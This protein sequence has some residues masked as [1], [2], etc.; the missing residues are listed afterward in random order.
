MSY[1]GQKNKYSVLN[2]F[3]DTQANEHCAQ[4]LGNSQSARLV[5]SP[6]FG[7]SSGVD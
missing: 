6:K 3:I 4:I 5:R 1:D 2:S 7:L